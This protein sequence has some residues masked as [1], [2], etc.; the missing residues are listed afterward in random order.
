MNKLIAYCGLNCEKCDAY[1]ATINNDQVLRE[2][3]AKLWSEM[4]HVEITPSM[5][6]CTG[7]RTDGV[8]TVYCSSMCEIRLCAH[9]KNVETCADCSGMNS[10][11]MLGMILN[12]NADAR[13]NLAAM[14][15]AD[16]NN[17]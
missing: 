10:C 2:K 4:N 1:I 3:T 13:T 7:C 6:E 5:I 15:S 11:E 14:G 16:G 12:T 17:Q 8:K 9:K